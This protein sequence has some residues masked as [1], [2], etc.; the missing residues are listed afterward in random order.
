MMSSGKISIEEYS[1]H[2]SRRSVLNRFLIIV[3][4]LVI[5][6]SFSL[7]RYGLKEGFLVT[8]L[9]W[10][11]FVLC[12]PI[13]D[14]G[15]LLDF[16]IRLLT[17]LR[18][19]Y[20]ELIVWTVALLLNIFALF[21]YEE[22][23]S[24]TFLLNIFHIILTTPFPYWSIIVISATGTFLS[25][26]FADELLDVITHKDRIRQNRHRRKYL[27]IVMIFLILLIIVFYKYMLKYMGVDF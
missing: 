10:S 4:V 2:K 11:L 15:F 13:A 20:S 24:R 23:Y 17:K 3:A 7:G 18:M 26:Y 22:V 8:F 25:I 14:A 16:P 6:L 21:F 1:K 27:M 12:T 9:T 5:Y 19:I